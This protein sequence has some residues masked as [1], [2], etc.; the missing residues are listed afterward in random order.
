MLVPR[1]EKYDAKHRVINVARR[2]SMDI[3]WPALALFAHYSSPHTPN[4]RTHP[5][6]PIWY[7]LLPFKQSILI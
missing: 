2:C 4:V 6:Y 7:V 5:L 3:Y 1:V